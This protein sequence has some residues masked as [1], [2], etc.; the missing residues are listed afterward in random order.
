[1]SYIRIVSKRKGGP[2]AHP[3]ELVI[4]VDRSNRILGNQNPV[5][6]TVSRAEAIKRNAHDLALDE[7][8]N[9][10]MSKELDR[11]AALVDAGTPVALNCWCNPLACHAENYREGI[12]RRLGR[13]LLPPEIFP[14]AE[15]PSQQA[16]F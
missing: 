8:R 4:D 1:M 10:P 5:S 7:A 3:G 13:T 12:E 14:K 6:A 15:S 9:G 11:I 16:L 2:Q